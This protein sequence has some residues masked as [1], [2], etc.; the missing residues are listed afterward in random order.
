MKHGQYKVWCFCCSF[1]TCTIHS[2]SSIPVLFACGIVCIVCDVKIKFLMLRPL[3]LIHCQGVDVNNSTTY[4]QSDCSWSTTWRHVRHSPAYI[5]WLTGDQWEPY[6][7]T[8][9]RQI[10][11]IT[12]KAVVKLCEWSYLDI[13]CPPKFT[14]TVCRVSELWVELNGFKFT[15]SSSI[16]LLLHFM[17]Y[18]A[19]KEIYT[20]K[21]DQ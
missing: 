5:V 2:L 4:R 18:V 9:R 21:K 15:A 1:H 19:H 13:R 16:H 14:L 8:V 17:L 20:Y 10:T 11:G 3:W 6:R 7:C 12:V